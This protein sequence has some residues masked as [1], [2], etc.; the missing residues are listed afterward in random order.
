MNPSLN[1]DMQS[2]NLIQIKKQEKEKLSEKENL[3][4]CLYC[5]ALTDM[6]VCG[7]CGNKMDDVLEKRKLYEN[8]RYS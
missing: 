1:L 3:Q 7:I 5:G 2:L 4:P 6:S 8:R